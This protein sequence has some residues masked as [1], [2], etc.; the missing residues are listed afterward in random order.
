M[1]LTEKYDIVIEEKEELKLIQIEIKKGLIELIS[2]IPI[3]SSEA[4]IERL[5]E[6]L[7]CSND[8]I[9]KLKKRRIETFG[10]KSFGS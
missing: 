4:I 10:R 5:L 6:M 9:V 3:G 8:D 1:S 7:K 2:K